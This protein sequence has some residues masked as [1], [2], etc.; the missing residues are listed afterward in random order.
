[1]LSNFKFHHLGYVTD[2]IDKTAAV[3]IAALYRA[4]HVSAV[5]LFPWLGAGY[6]HL[7][8]RL[9]FQQRWQQ[10]HQHSQRVAGLA[11]DDCVL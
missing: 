5:Q 9:S 10:R 1:M 8:L 11:I 7:L 6:H 3:Y 2:N 4:G